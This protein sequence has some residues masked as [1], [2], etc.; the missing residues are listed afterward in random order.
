MFF[1]VCSAA[2]AEKSSSHHTLKN[3]STTGGDFWCRFGN[4][5][6]FDKKE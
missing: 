5:K 3:V 2:G 6:K 1:K 4:K